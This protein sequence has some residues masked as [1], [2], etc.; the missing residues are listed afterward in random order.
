MKMHGPFDQIAINGETLTPGPDGAYEVPQANV[1]E[2]LD[3]GM[4]RGV[5][6]GSVPAVPPTTPV[7][8]ESTPAPE[9]RPEPKAE[10]IE[11]PRP[12]GKRRS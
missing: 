4:K 10:P 6:P 9:P 2:L 12:K 1:A 7:P 8:Q 11:A 3:I 5:P